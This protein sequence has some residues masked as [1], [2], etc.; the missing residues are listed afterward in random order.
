MKDENQIRKS[1]NSRGF[2]FGIW[3]DPPGQ[4]WSDFTHEVDE[5]F[6]GVEGEVELIIGGH[7]MHPKKNQEVIIPANCKHTVKNI[8]TTKSCWYYGYKKCEGVSR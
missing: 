8:G 7:L 5:L 4:V 2:S 6:M 1:W 3:Q